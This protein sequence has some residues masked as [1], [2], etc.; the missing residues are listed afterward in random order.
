MSPPPITLASKSATRVAILRNAGRGMK[1]VEAA[2]ILFTAPGTTTARLRSRPF[3]P[4]ATTG[5]ASIDPARGTPYGIDL[6]VITIGDMV[7]AQAMLID[8]LGIDQLFC[9]IGGS[10]GGMQ[11]LEWASK[12]PDRVFSAVPIAARS[13]SP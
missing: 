13:P 10:M 5:P 1:R 6:P 3:N 8:H 4:A 12:Y 9:V 7:R 11:V 2:P